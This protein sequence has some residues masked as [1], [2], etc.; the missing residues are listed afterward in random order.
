[1]SEPSTTSSA[2]I[3]AVALA[4]LA[5][6]VPVNVVLG[7]FAGAMLFVVT[8]ND[9]GLGKKIVLFLSSFV[10]GFLSAGAVTQLV[11]LIFGLHDV[12]TGVGALLSA[13]AAVRVMLSAFKWL[14]NPQMPFFG[15]RPGS[16]DNDHGGP[17]P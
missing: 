3:A 16:G 7:A 10:A 1:M 4:S 17:Y 11:E 14:E 6:G 15:R 12:D 9:F 13:A 5:P 8:S 2:A